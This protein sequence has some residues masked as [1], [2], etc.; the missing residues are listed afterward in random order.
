MAELFTPQEVA[1]RLKIGVR[2]V[3][4]YIQE[5]DFPNVICIKGQ[6]RIP[7]SDVEL[8]EHKSRVF[9]DESSPTIR[10]QRRRVISTGM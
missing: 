6:Y 4:E 3:Y 1:K 2:R 10:P 9:V 5:K 8:L 7:A